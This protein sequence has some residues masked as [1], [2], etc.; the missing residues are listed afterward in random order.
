M[1]KN[2]VIIS[3][4]ISV[5]AVLNDTDAARKIMENLPITG[6]INFWGDEI[7]FRISVRCDQEEEKEVVEKG[8]LGYWMPGQ[9]FCIFYGKTLSSIGDEIRP[10]SPVIVIGKVTGDTD[11]FKKMKKDEEIRIEA[12]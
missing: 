5:T 1:N 8:D 3:G 12:V 6:N 9:A 4:D 10:S 7:Y 11:L 2:I